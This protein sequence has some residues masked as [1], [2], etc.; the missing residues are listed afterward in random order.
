MNPLGGIAHVANK[1][2]YCL[3][4]CKFQFS[5]IIII[6]LIVT[7]SSIL[8]YKLDYL[9]LLIFIL[10]CNYLPN[11]G[12][13]LVDAVNLDKIKSMN[14]YEYAYYLYIPISILALKISNDNEGYFKKIPLA[15]IFFAL[16]AV[17]Y[18]KI[19]FVKNFF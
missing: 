10:I 5:P 18:A 9:K 19:D 12:W 14:F 15:F 7:I 4:D 8:K 11:L 3:I 6:L 2:D 1:T 17:F 16:T 13:F